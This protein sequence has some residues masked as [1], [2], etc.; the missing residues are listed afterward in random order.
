MDLRWNQG[1][2]GKNNVVGSGVNH[3]GIWIWN[4]SGKKFNY[5]G[6]AIGSN[7]TSLVLSIKKSGM[8]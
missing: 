7:E 4:T 1:K 3:Y 5:I 2:W 8:I 6:K